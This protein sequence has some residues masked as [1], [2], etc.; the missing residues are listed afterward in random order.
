MRVD[1]D[2]F[3]TPKIPCKSPAS[4]IK[5]T[6]S[7]N[8]L[9]DNYI[10]NQRLRVSS[11]NVNINGSKNAPVIAN[12]IDIVTDG[13]VQLGTGTL[14]PVLALSYIPSFGGSIYYVYVSGVI[15]GVRLHSAGA[16][17]TFADGDLIFLR[18]DFTGFTK[19]IAI[20][21]GMVIDG[22]VFTGIYDIAL[23]MWRAFVQP[24][25]HVSTSAPTAGSWRHGDFWYQRE[26]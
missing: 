9:P 11:A 15:T 1:V 10:G 6:I 4:R 22:N 26:A 25:H 8:R 5:N 21:V 13:R 16:A 7:E 20:P 24:R 17:E 2:R 19:D 12:V 14:L 18:E 3:L 23:D